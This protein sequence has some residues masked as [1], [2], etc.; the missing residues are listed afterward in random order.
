MWYAFDA[1]TQDNVELTVGITFFWQIVDVERMVKATDD[2]PGDVCSHARSAIIQ[3]VSQVPLETFLASFNEIVRQAVLGGEDHFYVERG[4]KIHA[5]EVR[6]VTCKDGET[7]RILQEIIRETTD[8]LNRL[9]KQN[10]ENE[11][12]LQR[13]NGEIEA[14][15]L[16]GELELQRLNSEIETEQRRGQLLQSRAE[17][18]RLAAHT[19]GEAEAQ[20][21]RALLEGM[22]EALPLAERL[23]VFN[24]LRK[25]EMLAGL[26]QGNAQLYFT[27]ADVNLSIETHPAPPATGFTAP[28]GLTG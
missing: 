23:A 17:N 9:Q 21:V 15:R 19:E 13:L 6:S 22:G 12:K 14:E 3:S 24:T 26:S 10:S 27:P 1:R 18:A 8:R 25:Q 20:R 28:K 2:T 16:R 4:V 11:V 7:Q 5:V